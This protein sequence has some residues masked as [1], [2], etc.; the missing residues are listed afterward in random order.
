MVLNYNPITG[1]PYGKVRK[2][3]GSGLK[4]QVLARSKGRCERCGKDVI[5]KGLKPRYHHKDGNP[6][7]NTLS[8]I[9]LLCNDCH[10]KVHV[11]KTKTEYHP[12]YG[13]TTRR[14]LVTKKIRKKGR[15]KK[16]IKRKK[17]SSYQTYINP[18]TGQREK[19]KKNSFGLGF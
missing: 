4:S 15:K 1:E 9:V 11:Y 13:K 18:I 16:A 12:F 17:S 19:I 6:S 14:V 7:H 10:D 5:G 2:N 8:N 3:V